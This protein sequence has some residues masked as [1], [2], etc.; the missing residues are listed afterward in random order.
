MDLQRCYNFAF[1]QLQ[2]LIL[3]V[4]ALVLGISF[5]SA[6]YHFISLKGVFISRTWTTSLLYII[7]RYILGQQMVFLIPII[8][9]VI[10]MS[11]GNDFTVFI[12]SRVR[13]EQNKFRFEEGL[14]RAM[15]GSGSV[16]TA[17]RLM[18]AVSLGSLALVP[19]GFLEQL[20][21][22]F[23]ISLI[24]DTFVIRIFLPPFD[25]IDLEK[26]TDSRP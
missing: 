19:F 22:P 10:L 17:L 25:P 11:Q 12:F 14:A 4:I 5:R 26:Q 18:L 9:Y 13:E 6:R 20:G 2:L 21:I 23:V 7:S 1:A 15:V 24:V 8:L 16:V 3:K